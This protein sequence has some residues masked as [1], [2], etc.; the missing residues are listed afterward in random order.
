MKAGWA[1]P[2]CSRWEKEAQRNNRRRLRRRAFKDAFIET[3]SFN[4]EASLTGSRQV[5]LLELKHICS[6][7]FPKNAKKT[8]FI[9]IFKLK[10]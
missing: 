7:C 8:A 5:D 10:K 1:L 3:R 6:A 4:V 2:E 9:K